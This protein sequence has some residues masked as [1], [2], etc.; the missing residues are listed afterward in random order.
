MR[1]PS[2]VVQGHQ[3]LEVRNPPLAPP[4]GQLALLDDLFRVQRIVEPQVLALEPSQLEQ[5]LGEVVSLLRGVELEEEGVVF[6]HEYL[7][8][9]LGAD[10]PPPLNVPDTLEVN[11]LA[12]LLEP[13]VPPEEEEAILVFD[14]RLVVVLRPLSVRVKV[15]EYQILGRE[16][17]GAFGLVKGFHERAVGLDDLPLSLSLTQARAF[18]VLDVEALVLRH[19]AGLKIAL[20]E[21]EL[22][23]L[24]RARHLASGELPLNVRVYAPEEF[25]LQVVVLD[26]LESVV[27]PLLQECLHPQATVALVRRFKVLRAVVRPEAPVQ[28]ERG[29][30]GAVLLPL[31]DV[32][33]ED[34]QPRVDLLLVGELAHLAHLLEGVPVDSLLDVLLRLL[35]PGVHLVDALAVGLPPRQEELLYHLR[36]HLRPQNLIDLLV[37]EESDL[38]VLVAKVLGEVLEVRGL[39]ALDVFQGD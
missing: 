34:L 29:P 26:E 12:E 9:A 14:V 35:G 1:S 27:G 15:D 13:H 28:E 25:A 31:V 20:E 17:Q 16:N 5:L 11:F 37:V 30:Q 32:L 33:D 22:A 10:E 4:V 7:K 8:A 38:P 19:D 3:V 6:N 23:A 24:A 21:P 18:D 36:A 2:V 39:V